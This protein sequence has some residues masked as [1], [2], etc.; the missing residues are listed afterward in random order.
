MYICLIDGHVFIEI[1]KDNKYIDSLSKRKYICTHAR[2]FW[3]EV[4]GCY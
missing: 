3:D 1:E 4:I 2:M